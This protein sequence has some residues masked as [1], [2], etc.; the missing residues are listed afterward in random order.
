MSTQVQD[1]HT[2]D[3]S[4]FAAPG[5]WGRL[6]FAPFTIAPPQDFAVAYRG[7]LGIESQTWHFPGATEQTLEILLGQLGLRAEIVGRM[8][9]LAFDCRT[10]AGLSIIPPADLVA[11][12]SRTERSELYHW[13]SHATGSSWQANA[14]RFCGS[15]D[16]WF[17]LSQLDERTIELVEHYTYQRENYLLFADLPLVAEQLQ[18]QSEFARLIKVLAREKT[19]LAKLHVHADDNLDELTAYWS[20]GRSTLDVRPILE[21]LAHSQRGHAI[22]IVHLLPNFARRLLYTYPQLNETSSSIH[23]DCHWSSLNFYNEVPQDAMANLQ[24][25]AEVVQRDWQQINTPPQLGDLVFF[26]DERQ[27]IFHSAVHIADDVLFTKNGPAIVR[28]WIL[29]RERDLFGFYPQQTKVEVIY[30][31]RRDLL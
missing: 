2:L 21:S 23:R 9:S 29:M 30:Y 6:E 12:L 15:F 10:Q 24:Y 17:A 27:N 11:E 13:L 18:D 31:R 19:M 3:D 5:P 4:H 28:P 25:V 20:R 16:D 22:D 26:Q 8:L 7:L 1:Q 14:F